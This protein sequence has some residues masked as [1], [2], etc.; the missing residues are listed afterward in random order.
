MYTLKKFWDSK[1]L[2]PAVRVET[3]NLTY[4]KFPSAPFFE[5][6]WKKVCKIKK[7]SEES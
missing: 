1:I 6:T 3:V 5:L 7:I 2:I 4:S